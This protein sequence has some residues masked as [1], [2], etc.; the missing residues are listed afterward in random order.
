MACPFVNEVVDV[1]AQIIQRLLRQETVIRRRLDV[2]SFVE[3][4]LY[5]KYC[6]TSQSFILAIFSTP[7]Y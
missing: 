4:E 1:E 3:E 7:L 5:E 6:F 2:L